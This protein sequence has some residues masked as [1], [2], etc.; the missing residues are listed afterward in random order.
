[1]FG[2]FGAAPSVAHGVHAFVTASGI[3]EPAPWYAYVRGAIGL[4]AAMLFRC[5]PCLPSG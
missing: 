5:F 1:M 4:P 2:F 3:A